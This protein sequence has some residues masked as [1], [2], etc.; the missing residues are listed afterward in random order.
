MI[1]V[2]TKRV[3]EIKKL[4]ED[5][6]RKLDVKLKFVPSGIEVDGESFSEYTASVVLE[7]IKFGFSVKKA[8]LLKEEDFVFKIIHIKSHTR[9]NLR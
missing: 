4:K 5:L 6:E 7:A 9:R 3:R 8:L 2:Y 1:T